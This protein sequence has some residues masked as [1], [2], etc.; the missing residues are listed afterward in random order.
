L[1]TF[2]S[3]RTVP[4]VRCINIL[5]LHRSRR[6]RQIQSKQI[7]RGPT[8]P[9]IVTLLVKPQVKTSAHPVK[10]CHHQIQP[11]RFLG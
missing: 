11:P 6:R 3:L 9:E 10:M 8:I 2:P 7:P 1:N 4:L 5:D